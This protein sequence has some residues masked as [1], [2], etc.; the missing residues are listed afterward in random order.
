MRSFKVA[1][2]SDDRDQL[3]NLKNRVDT[4]LAAE[5]VLQQR[6]FPATSGDTVLRDLQQARADV[7]MVDFSAE[8]AESAV[9]AIEL[10][11]GL[12][13]GS[14][15]FAL[16]ALNQPLAIINAMR[17]GACEFLDRNS[18]S[19]ALLEAFSRL[20]TSMQKRRSAT[21]ERGKLFTLLSAKGGC[22]ATTVAVNLAIVL[23]KE[24]GNVALVDLATL[25]HTP[26]HLNAKP[27]FGI[28]D[29]IRNLH[30][31]DTTLLE[32]FMTECQ[33][34]LH[35]LAG[36]NVPTAPNFEPV[37]L[38][39]LFDQLLA[40]YKYVVVDCSNRTDM[41][42]RS[43][44]DHSDMVLLVAQ[45]DVASLW[46]AGRVREFLG[47]EQGSNKVQI[48]VNRFRK[49]AGF[50]DEDVE[51]ATMCKIFWKIPNQ[52]NAIGP[53][54]DRGN[55][56]ALQANSE[57]A[58]SFKELAAALIHTSPQP[59]FHEVPSGLLKRKEEPQKR[60]LERLISLT[61]VSSTD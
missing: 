59:Q 40:H 27:N 49:I 3:T 56:V 32:T 1:L 46:S 2:L 53:A 8:H 52:F 19:S 18:S 54:I 50:N 25:G 55:P 38:A 42:S 11:H 10:L 24:Q 35:L 16:S 37:D 48:I 28:T 33:G 51:S 20:S 29:A 58:R 14:S 43:V 13:P 34:G 15:I 26:L 4:T 36:V 61:P 57:V 41:T 21:A 44:C 31:L 30:R 22:G 12:F 39:Q 47:Q 60:I 7:I 45:T 5:T 6:G 23:Q 17:A 9:A